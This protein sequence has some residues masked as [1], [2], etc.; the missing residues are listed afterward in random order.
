MDSTLI[1]GII[2]GVS[3]ITAV[4]IPIAQKHFETKTLFP[5]STDRRNILQGK[6]TG[7]VNQHIDKNT[8]NTISVE[9]NIKINIKQ[10][11]IYG[12]GIINALQIYHVSLDGSFRNDRFLKMDYQNIDSSIVQFGSFVFHL[13][14]DSKQLKGRFVGYGHISKDIISGSCQFNKN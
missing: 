8:F 14:D 12:T 2:G 1:A 5:I 6:W 4:V 11:K 3:T 9:L 13:S 7:T 10:R